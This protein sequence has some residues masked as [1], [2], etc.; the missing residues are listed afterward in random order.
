ML[1][2]QITDIG[3]SAQGIPFR[4]R[5]DC[6]VNHLFPGFF[7]LVPDCR[8]S[9]LCRPSVVGR[10]L[11]MVVVGLDLHWRFGECRWLSH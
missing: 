3:G 10:I 7:R 2:P 6:P 8:S 9:P 4:L 1:F 11:A 5:T